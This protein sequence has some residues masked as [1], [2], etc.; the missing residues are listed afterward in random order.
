MASC[1]GVLSMYLLLRPRTVDQSRVV[2]YEYVIV[3]SSCRHFVFCSCLISASISVL[4]DL[5]FS[6][7]SGVGNCLRRVFLR[8]ILSFMLRENVGL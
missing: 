6:R 1:V 7:I 4:R 8:W 5:I 2:L 3:S